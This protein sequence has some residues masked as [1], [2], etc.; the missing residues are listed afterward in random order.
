VIV[1]QGTFEE[2]TYVRGKWGY[3]YHHNWEADELDKR[4]KEVAELLDGGGI[5]CSLLTDPFLD[6]HY[7][8]GSH[9]DYSDT[10]LSKRLLNGAVCERR[11]LKER[12]VHLRSHVN[13]FDEFTRL[14]AAAWSY[15]DPRRDDSRIKVLISSR[16]LPVGFVRG[17]T[18]VIPSLKPDESSVSGYLVV[19]A[20]GLVR[21]REHLRD[22]LPAWVN[23]FRFDE[24]SRAIAERSTLEI[25]IE[26]L[27]ARLSELSRFKTVLTNKNEALVDSVVNALEAGLGLTTWREEAFREDLQLVDETGSPWALLEVK[28]TNGG[29]QRVHVNH[30]NQ[31]DSH[32]ERAKLPETFPTLLII[33]TQAKQTSLAGKDQEVAQ[34]QVEKAVRDNILIL[35]TLDLLH[36]VAMRLDG[37]VTSEKVR[38]LLSTSR[39]WL[40]V[41]NE[42]FRVVGSS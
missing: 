37:R 36:L 30:V 26:E 34:E 19:L 40:E 11:N 18:F 15:F 10:D 4:E 31:A 17:G 29:V 2:F 12:H 28:G 33:N 41:T 9:R 20:E 32:R 13:E 8:D 27:E 25:R 1:F 22:Q 39:G 16:N 5:V 3:Y 24:E 42:Q 35:R 38:E 23:E 6:S 21:T 7:Y 14:H